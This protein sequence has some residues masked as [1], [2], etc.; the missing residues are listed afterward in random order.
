MQKIQPSMG[1]IMKEIWKMQNNTS[2]LIILLASKK[3]DDEFQDEI[4]DLEDTI[5]NLQNKIDKKI[6][7]LK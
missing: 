6:D 2:K 3:D 5:K 7:D 4:K 1:K